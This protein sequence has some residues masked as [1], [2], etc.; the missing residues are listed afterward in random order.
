[1]AKHHIESRRSISG[2]CILVGARCYEHAVEALVRGNDI[3]TAY[4]LASCH[5]PAEKWAVRIR[6]ILLFALSLRAQGNGDSLQSLELMI[7]AA[8]IKSNTPLSSILD[9]ELHAAMLASDVACSH[10][11]RVKLLSLGGI[12]KTERELVEEAVEEDKKAKPDVIKVVRNYLLAQRHADA[13]EVLVRKDNGILEALLL[14]WTMWKQLEPCPQTTEPPELLFSVYS[15][16]RHVNGLI[17]SDSI[18]KRKLVGCACWLGGWV[19]EVCSSTWVPGICLQ[20]IS[21]VLYQRARCIGMSGPPQHAFMLAEA[22][23]ILRESKAATRTRLDEAEALIKKASEVMVRKDDQDASI[24]ENA[25]TWVN[26]YMKQ[27]ADAA[28]EAAALVSPQERDET[29]VDVTNMSPSS[30]LIG[31]ATPCGSSIPTTKVFSSNSVFDQGYIT[32]PAIT[33]EDGISVM[34]TGDAVM[35]NWVNPFSPLA[36]GD[37]FFVL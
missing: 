24:I 34:S 17:L 13:V 19:A 11:D 37:R 35:W 14:E 1:M 25:G 23:C 6:Q 33:L 28:E 32:G 27:Q 22:G 20:G 3:D 16:I 15:L 12:N 36:S 5:I 31:P 7:A 8:S 4:A 18:Q 29:M 2:A 9:V 26:R 21:R 30:L 10:E